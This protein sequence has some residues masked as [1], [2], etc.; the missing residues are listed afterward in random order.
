M[1]QKTFDKI[2]AGLR[3]QGRLG[4]PLQLVDVNGLCCA[5]GVLILESERHLAVGRRTRYYRPDDTTWDAEDHLN[6]IKCMTIHDNW[7][8][9]M[10][11]EGFLKA[12]AQKNGVN[13][14]E[15]V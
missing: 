14:A 3:A 7:P 13:Y 8:D 5:T 2:A 4:T 11:V 1:P 6:G 15:K 9:R 12:I 10:D